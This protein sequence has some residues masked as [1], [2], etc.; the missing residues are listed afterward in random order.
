M[1]E[2][3]EAFVGRLQT[4]GVEAGRQA[5]AKIEAEAQE[6]AARLLKDA[7]ARASEIRKQAETDA[8][9]F[10]KR[11]EGEL[12]LA[13]RDSI[14][15]LRETFI[16]ML[17]RVLAVRVEAC[18]ADDAFLRTLIQEV[19]RQYARA[20]SEERGDIS[21]S[22][23]PEM[24]RQLARWAVHELRQGLDAP[25][26]HVDL[27]GTLEKAGFEYRVTNGTVEVTTESVV[28]M[29]SELVRPELRRILN[30]SD[31]AQL[32]RGNGEAAQAR[33]GGR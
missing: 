15:A 7:E 18:L 2:T 12:Q 11:M 31:L 25:G 17:N 19:L 23:T 20:D 21:I 26:R 13:V 9:L 30:E 5:A 3:I 1:P 14:V 32:E 6:R 10:R 24:E 28:A 29:L 27:H 22:V 16:G 8:A 4:E 33:S